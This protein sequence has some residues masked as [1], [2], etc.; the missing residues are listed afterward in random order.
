[1]TSDHTGLRVRQARNFI[2]VREKPVGDRGVGT[3]LQPK[4]LELPLPGR[5]QTF[6]VRLGYEAVPATE[7]LQI[8]VER[9]S[10][11]QLRR[12][13]SDPYAV[14]VAAALVGPGNRRVA[15]LVQ[16]ASG[17]G[18]TVE[19]E[20]GT[21]KIVISLG[22]AVS[23]AA[24]P[25]E[26]ECLPIAASARGLGWTQVLAYSRIV[27]HHIFALGVASAGGKGGI[28]LHT[29]HGEGV[30]SL[31]FGG[32]TRIRQYRYYTRAVAVFTVVGESILS[33]YNTPQIVAPGGEVGV[34]GSGKLAAITW[35]QEP[36]DRRRA[37]FAADGTTVVIN[38]AYIDLDADPAT[39]WARL[40]QV[41]HD[42]YPP[43]TVVVTREMTGLGVAELIGHGHLIATPP[44]SP[45]VA[46]VAVM[47]FAQLSTSGMRGCGD[48]IDA[49]SGRLQEPLP[50]P[51]PA[52]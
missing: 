32:V 5:A 22:M 51:L 52:P 18:E 9:R 7:V 34:W 30:F 20:A 6:E 40:E 31:D 8:V 39:V 4:P 42:L 35:A 24:V 48:V 43:S 45:A 19:V 33:S 26:L 10:L 17:I 36:T 14:H 21:Y 38:R 37:W 16:S 29:L 13:S 50:Q 15:P 49:S 12:L 47:G 1:M 23:L 44:P 41:L 25:F 3:L 28:N 27:Q 46:R 2:S 11:L